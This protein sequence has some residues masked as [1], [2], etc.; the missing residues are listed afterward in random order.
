MK[1]EELI[2]R[3]DVRNLLP[4][5]CTCACDQITVGAGA[6]FTEEVVLCTRQQDI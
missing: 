3:G 4:D 2:R 1:K 6:Q 5:T